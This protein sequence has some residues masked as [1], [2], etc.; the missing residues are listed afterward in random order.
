MFGQKRASRRRVVPTRN[1]PWRRAE[2]HDQAECRLWGGRFRLR[3]VE[4]G[5]EAHATPASTIALV[6]EL[7]DDHPY[8]EAVKILNEKG[9]TGGWGKPFTVPSLTQLCRNRGIPSH[10]D[11]LRA[12]GML[13]LEEVADQFG[14]STRTVKTWQHRGHI[15]GRRVDGRRAHLYYPGQGRP[16]DGRRR[17]PRPAPEAVTADSHDHPGL[18]AKDK[19][20]TNSP[21][22][23]V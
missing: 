23:A 2:P 18:V 7:L 19:T 15:T 17:H 13:T 10:F 14:V 6:D 12:K 9:L 11:R 20:T 16:P 21:G 22:G 8:D 5:R 1:R 4:V 3:T